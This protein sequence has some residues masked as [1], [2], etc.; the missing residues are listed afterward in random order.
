MGAPR[1]RVREGVLRGRR[2]SPRRGP[3]PAG[4]RPSHLGLLMLGVGRGDEVLVPTFTFAATAECREVPRCGPRSSS[5]SDRETWNMDP[6][7]LEEEL[8]AG[9]PAGNA[10]EGGCRCRPLRAVRGLRPDPGPPAAHG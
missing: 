9:R 10:P 4:R 5:T 6:G 8:A 2:G 7:L 3:L 1:G